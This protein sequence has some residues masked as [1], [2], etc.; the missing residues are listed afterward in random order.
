MTHH[1]PLTH[2]H[3]SAGEWL[4]TVAHHLGTEDR[5][6]T[7]RVLRAWLHLVRDRLTVDAAAHFAAQLPEFLRGVYY[8]GWTPAKVPVRYDAAGFTNLFAD[9]AGISPA[10]VPAVASGVSSAM[11]ALCSPGQ[12]DHVFALMPANLR[13]ELEGET[14]APPPRAT[15]ERL[16]I[17]ALED[18]VQAL[19]EAVGALARGLEQLPD[20]EP[21]ADRTAK[22]AQ[23]AHRILMTDAVQ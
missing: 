14:P 17:N 8:D 22:A 11:S 7:F 9:R 1:D 2:A 13:G 16:R 20:S 23:E 3:Q 4:G 19:T 21:A 6:F 12:L 18:R 15:S 10:D 5:H